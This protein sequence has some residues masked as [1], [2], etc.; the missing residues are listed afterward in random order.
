MNCTAL[1]ESAAGEMS[2]LHWSENPRVLATELKEEDWGLSP[3]PSR[4]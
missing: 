2:L 3:L 4:N 1:T